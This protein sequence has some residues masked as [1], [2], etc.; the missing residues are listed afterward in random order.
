MEEQALEVHQ[1]TDFFTSFYNIKKDLLGMA[2]V[3]FLRQATHQIFI[4]RY[5]R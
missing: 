1:F 5:L 4:I 3:S 2:L